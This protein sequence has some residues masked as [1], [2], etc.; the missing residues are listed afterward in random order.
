MEL[1]DET[2]SFK[3]SD[4][5]QMPSKAGNSD[6]FSVLFA[7]PNGF[8]GDHRA[9][10]G[11]ERAPKAT[12][13]SHQFPQ[14]CIL[15]LATAIKGSK[16]YPT[17]PKKALKLQKMMGKKHTRCSLKVWNDSNPFATK[18]TENMNTN[19]NTVPELPHGTL[20][21][22]RP[23]LAMNRKAPFCSLRWLR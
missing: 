20:C 6:D 4:L 17:G 1:R 16:G 22:F 2:N 9:P 12:S 14:N 8:K 23:D 18:N 3:N 15:A 21:A 13:K 5:V 10:K 11:S 7:S 19:L